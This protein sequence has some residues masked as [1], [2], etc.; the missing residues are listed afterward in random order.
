MYYSTWCLLCCPEVLTV[1]AGELPWTVR[2][3]I[4]GERECG[5]G[6]SPGHNEWT[7]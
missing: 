7:L 3:V 4:M 2:L 6:V 5:L 1:N